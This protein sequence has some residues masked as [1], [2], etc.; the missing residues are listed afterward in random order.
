MMRW[1]LF[2]SLILVFAACDAFEPTATHHPNVPRSISATDGQTGVFTVQYPG[3]WVALEQ[4]DN[5]I[6]IGNSGFALR[7]YSDDITVVQSGQVVGTVGMLPKS[8]VKAP[9]VENSV[10]GVM[11]YFTGIVTV[12][13]DGVNYSFGSTQIV[14]RKDKTIAIVEGLG[15]RDNLAFD[16]RVMIVDAGEAYGVM[17]FGTPFDEIDRYTEPLDFIAANFSFVPMADYEATPVAP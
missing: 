16:L 7:I 3:D 17:F 6:S 12:P 2:I 15:T 11:N 13:L 10:Q 8:A 9:H 14:R 4:S 5:S 1:L